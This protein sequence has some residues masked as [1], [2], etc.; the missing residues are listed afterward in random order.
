VEKV[1]KGMFVSVDYKG[2]LENGEIFDSSHGRQ[3]LEIQMGAGQLIKGFEKELLGMAVNEKKVFS[4]EPEDAYGRRDED[5]SQS[6]ARSDVPPELNPRVGMTVGV[7]S[8]EGHQIPARITYVDN[9]KLTL[10]LN[11]PL[12]GETLTFEIEVK[13]ISNTPTQSPSACGSGCDCSSGCEC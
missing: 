5:L 11:H 13:G 3:P 7:R 9:E 10:D 2:S 8:P 4:V 12:A 6:F 1:E